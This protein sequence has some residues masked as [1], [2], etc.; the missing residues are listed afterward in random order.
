M[1]MYRDFLLGN[2]PSQTIQPQQLIINS[3]NYQDMYGTCFLRVLPDMQCVGCPI[4][5][6]LSFGKVDIGNKFIPI[7]RCIGNLCSRVGWNLL[8][9]VGLL[10]AFQ[11]RLSQTLLQV[12]FLRVIL[13][14][15]WSL[16]VLFGRINFWIKHLFLTMG[17]SHWKM[18]I[19]FLLLQ[20][21]TSIVVSSTGALLSC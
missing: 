13:G 2:N 5:S 12:W 20:T 18:L 19:S 17:E 3:L 4:A 11:M 21:L 9:I 8:E 16:P 14:Q 6:F 15:V 7:K 10:W 1:Y